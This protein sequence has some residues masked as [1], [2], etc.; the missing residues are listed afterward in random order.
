M[1]RRMQRL[2]QLLYCL[3][4]CEWEGVLCTRVMFPRDGKKTA[5]LNL[6]VLVVD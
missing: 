4:D 2:G 3:P 5:L 1:L 6:S